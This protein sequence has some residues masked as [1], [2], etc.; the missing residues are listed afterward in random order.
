M[1]LSRGAVLAAVAL[2]VG[3][4]VAAYRVGR[5][6]A[7]GVPMVNPLYYGGVLDDGGRPI[8][9]TRNVT[10][11]LW[12]AATAGATACTTTAAGTAFSGGRFRVALDGS[13]VGA[14]RANPELWAELQV[15]G[16]VFPRSKLGAVPYALEAGRASAAAGTL[17][18]RLAAVEAASQPRQIEFGGSGG[19][20]EYRCSGS[21]LG[22]FSPSEVLVPST[23]I[24]FTANSTGMY[25]VRSMCSV[26]GRA[27]LRWRSATAPA[28][29][30]LTELTPPVD[31]NIATGPDNQNYVSRDS[32][33][34]V[35]LNATAVAAESIGQYTRGSV[36]T[37][38]LFAYITSVQQ[39][40]SARNQY[41]TGTVRCGR[42]VATQLQ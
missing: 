37:M 33:G 36:Y 9:G 7:D 35:Y 32:S 39:G 24:T 17:E 12:D 23:S 3:G 34:N 38:Q 1:R 31:G 22:P 25:S 30:M 2:S 20:A 15:E 10:V 18:T 28:P 14:V 42:V 16:T 6:R 26:S 40:S 5:A 41:S 11:R 19:T 29:S 13:C 21:C 4:T 27:E 8:E